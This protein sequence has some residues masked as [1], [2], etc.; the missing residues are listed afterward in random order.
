MRWNLAFVMLAGV[1]LACSSPAADSDKEKDKGGVSVELDGMKS[2][3]PGSWV[4]EKPSNKM[5]FAQFRLPKAKD[6]KEDAELVIFKGLGGSSKANVERWKKQFIPPKG[7]KIED[8]SKVTEIKIGG[9]AAT[10]LDV[11][12]TYRYNPQPFNPRSKEVLR[13][14]YRMLAIHFEGPKDVYHIK[15]TGP[16]KTIEQYKKGF[17]EWIKGFKK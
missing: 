1:A 16:A 8:V 15:L 13:P 3:T 17:D 14:G 12:G 6:D 7:K 11:S 4:E 9:D 10:L 2:K 5:R